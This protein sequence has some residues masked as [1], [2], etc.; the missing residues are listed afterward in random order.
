MKSCFYLLSVV[1]REGKLL[2]MFV[3]RGMKCKSE[4]VK[5]H[6]QKLRKLSCVCAVW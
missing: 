4:S 6:N 2:K 5:S 3:K 1:E